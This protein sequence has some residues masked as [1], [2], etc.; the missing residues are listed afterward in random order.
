MP[1][2]RTRKGTGGLKTIRPTGIELPSELKRVHYFNGQILSATDFVVEQTYFMEKCRLHNRLL[3]GSGIV[4]GL[5]VLVDEARIAVQPGCALDCQGNLILL[6]EATPLRL[7]IEGDKSQSLR[8]VVLRY[9]ECDTDPVP[10]A[11]APCRSDDDSFAPS[12]VKDGFVLNLDLEAP[13]VG[14][15]RY[16]CGYYACGRPHGMPLARLRWSRGRWSLDGRFIAPR[17]CHCCEKQ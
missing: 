17:M 11:G 8:Y 4:A 12:R 16:F 15:P 14:H 3:H 9:S 2:K 5:E 10:I 6:P 7:P 1:P 13:G